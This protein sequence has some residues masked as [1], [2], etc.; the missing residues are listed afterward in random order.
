MTNLYNQR[1]ETSD[2]CDKS[3]GLMCKEGVC[4]CEETKLYWNEKMVSCG[5][6]F[7]K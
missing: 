6:C 2:E 3:K 1:C 4:K 7:K 5:N